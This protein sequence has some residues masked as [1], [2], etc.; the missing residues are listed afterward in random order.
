MRNV[1][2]KPLEKYAL[3]ENLLMNTPYTL[4]E[5]MATLYPTYS[6]ATGGYTGPARVV[7]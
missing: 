3:I 4:T 2:V 6:L 5:I 7:H 1:D